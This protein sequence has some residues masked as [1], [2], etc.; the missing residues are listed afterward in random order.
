MITPPDRDALRMISISS[1]APCVTLDQKIA[2]MILV[3]ME[4]YVLITALY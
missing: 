1:L 2:V 4:R 3:P